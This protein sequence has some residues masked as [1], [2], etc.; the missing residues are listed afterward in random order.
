M[1][2]QRRNLNGISWLEVAQP[3]PQPLVDTIQPLVPQGQAEVA[4]SLY[5]D[6]RARR[7]TERRRKVDALLEERGIRPRRGW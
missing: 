6:D 1:R 7:D 2:S 5:G 4:V 3:L